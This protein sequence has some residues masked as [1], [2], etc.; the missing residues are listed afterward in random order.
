[1]NNAYPELPMVPYERTTVPMV[2]VIAHIQSTGL[3]PEIQRAG[4][5]LFRTESANGTAGINNNYIGMQ[6]DSGEWPASLTHYFSGV[7]EEVENGTGRTRLFL[8]FNRWEDCVDCLLD[9]VQ[10]RGLYIEAKAVPISHMLVSTPTDLV[11]AYTKEW[12]QGNA[13]AEPSA[14]TIAA[15]QS[16]YKQAVGLFP[17]HG[18]APTPVVTHVAADTGA[19]NSADALNAAEEQ[20]IK[21]G[22]QS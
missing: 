18:L 21:Q 20:R 16:M 14:D 6:A 5:I 10:A 9:R 15:W 1:M 12:A 7:V 8:A 3:D 11:R 17:H 2:D 4:Y 19:D 13:K 22:S